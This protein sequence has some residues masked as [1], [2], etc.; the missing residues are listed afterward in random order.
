MGSKGN[1]EFPLN[2]HIIS[3]LGVCDGYMRSEAGAY[4]KLVEI[5]PSSKLDELN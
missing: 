4:I 5:Y 2:G 1:D 3:Q